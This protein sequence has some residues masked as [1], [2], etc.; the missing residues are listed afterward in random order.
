MIAL[1]AFAAALAGVVLADPAVD[2]PAPAFSGA[3]ASGETI[4]LAQFEGRTVI[5]EWTNDGCPFVRKHYETGNMQLM[6]RAAQSTGAVWITVMSSAPGKQGH[7]D[8]ARAAALKSQ[9]ASSPDYI[10]LD[11]DGAV[12][13]AYGAKT[14]PQMAVIDKNGVLRYQGAID[15]KPSANPASVKGAINYVLAA[16][17]HVDKGEPVAVKETRPYGCAV[18]YKS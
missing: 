13:R 3:A 5:L 4:S 11:A 14:T 17:Y 12:G 16:L 6:Q 7:A 18:K 10:L 2:A 1:L 8:A 15:D 9:W